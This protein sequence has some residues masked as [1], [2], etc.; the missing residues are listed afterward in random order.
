M[1]NSQYDVWNDSVTY[2]LIDSFKVSSLTDDD[3]DLQDIYNDCSFELR[4]K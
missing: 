1:D 3:Q 4:V 2:E